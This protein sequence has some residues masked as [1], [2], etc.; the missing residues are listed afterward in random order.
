MLVTVSCAT[1]FPSASIMSICNTSWSDI[2]FNASLSSCSLYYM[3]V[4]LYN[5]VN[6]VSTSGNDDNLHSMKIVSMSLEKESCGQNLCLSFFQ[7]LQPIWW[8]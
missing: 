4:R 2:F 7:I 1:V 6:T 5:Y 8:N 3:M